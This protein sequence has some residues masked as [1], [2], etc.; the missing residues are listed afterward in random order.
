MAWPRFVLAAAWMC[1]SAPPV[2]TPL[3]RNVAGA[4][5]PLNPNRLRVTFSLPVMPRLE[6]DDT[7]IQNNS[8]NQCIIT[9]SQLITSIA[10]G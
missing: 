3:P 10:S 9:R 7:T 1:P 6:K 5:E 4:E 2:A 8:L